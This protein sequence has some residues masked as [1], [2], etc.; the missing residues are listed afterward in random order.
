MP[1]KV[2]RADFSVPVSRV[3]GTQPGVAGVL[4]E[5]HTEYRT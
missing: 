1:S 4:A 3:P 2:A 5:G